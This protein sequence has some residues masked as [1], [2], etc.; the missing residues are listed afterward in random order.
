MNENGKKLPEF[1]ALKDEINK[2]ASSFGDPF[3]F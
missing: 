3:E 2:F 1:V